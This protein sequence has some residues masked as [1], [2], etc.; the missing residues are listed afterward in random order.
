MNWS[1]SKG[2]SVLVCGLALLGLAACGGGGGDGDPAPKPPG[3]QMRVMPSPGGGQ[4]PLSC[5]WI[6]K[7]DGSTISCKIFSRASSDIFGLCD[8]NTEYVDTR[9]IDQCARTGSNVITSCRR[10]SGSSYG[11]EELFYNETVARAEAWRETCE[12]GGGTYTFLAGAPNNGGTP[13]PSSPGTEPESFPSPA[14]LSAPPQ[15]SGQDLPNIEVAGAAS[16]SELWVRNGGTGNLLI[17]AGTWYEPK[18]GSA[19]R[20]IVTASE[21]VAAGQ[22]ARVSAACMQGSKATPR[23]GLRFFSAAKQI[24]GPVQQCQARCLS[25]SGGVQS[26]VW[27]C[28]GTQQ[29][30]PRPP[31]TQS[32]I[33]DITM[34]I[35]ETETIDLSRYFTDPDGDRLTYSLRFSTGGENHVTAGVSGNS[36]TIRGRAGGAAAVRV[37]AR[38]PG[39]LSVYQDFTVQVRVWYAIAVSSDFRSVGYS[40]SHEN[41]ASARSAAVA[42]CQHAGGTG[43]SVRSNQGGDSGELVGFNS[44]YAVARNQL[45]RLG[46]ATGRGTQSIAESD[47]LRLCGGGC[48][49]TTW[50][51]SPGGRASGCVGVN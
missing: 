40:G 16:T 13:P 10:D 29:S 26:C 11:D 21:T 49:I 42:A 32:S 4:G 38:D 33:P 1:V 27:G 51:S 35:G 48:S 9:R 46:V 44:C 8:L 15:A 5:L 30:Q 2:L 36:L 24:S 23:T 47:A 34:G 31:R 18:D 12:L 25:G 50:G 14:P 45:G 19:Q 7:I 41:Q 3:D 6:S 43:C 22:F 17:R 37:T 39:G 28:E 20:M